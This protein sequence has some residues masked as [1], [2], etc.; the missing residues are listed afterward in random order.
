MQL[1]SGRFMDISK[2]STLTEPLQ[3]F[4]K[5]IVDDRGA[6]SFVNDLNLKL[7]TRQYLVENHKV[8]FVR[9]WHGHK[10]ETKIVQALSGVALV[11]CVKI[12]NW[13]NPSKDL[14]ISRFTVS[15]ENPSIL[16]IPAGFANGFMNLTQET[17]L[18][19]T[20]DKS[21]EESLSDDYRFESRYWDPWFI[22]ER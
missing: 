6:V 16:I 9:A 17:K 20:S 12:T 5:K 3:L 4:G 8:G 14:E 21:L 18:L 11:C 13:E 19:F 7:F 22:V 10:N 2:L 15:S 1:P